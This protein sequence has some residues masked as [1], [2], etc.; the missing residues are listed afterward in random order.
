MKRI[1]K[2]LVNVMAVIVL[3]VSALS[4]TACNDVSTVEVKFNL[5]NHAESTFISEE[6]VTLSID[7]YGHL[8]PETVKTIKSYFS[9]GYYD[10]AIIY[11]LAGDEGYQYMVGDLEYKDGAIVKKAMKPAIKGEFESN[12]VKNGEIKADKGSV[13]LWR[14]YYEVDGVLN[15]SSAARN[16]ASATLFMPTEANKSIDG[17]VCLFGKFDAE[18]NQAVTFMEALDAIFASG[19]YTEEY[20]IYYTGAQE[21]YDETKENAG[22][23]FNCVLASEFNADDIENLFEAKGQQ[24]ACYSYYTIKVPTLVT[25][26]NV[27]SATIKSVTVK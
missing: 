24:L 3:G 27:A 5:Y 13:G 14:S 23:T 19:E 18:S 7:L 2:L 8:A 10:N 4:L 9:E 20:V 25:E 22:L 16:S 11:Q 15:T 17:Y 21:D 6:D 1:F 12:G 26:N